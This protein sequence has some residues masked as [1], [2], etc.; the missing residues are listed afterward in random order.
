M[1]PITPIVTHAQIVRTVIEESRV[2]VEYTEGI[3]DEA[4]AYKP[5]RSLTKEITGTDYAALCGR[6]VKIEDAS[7]MQLTTLYEV[8]KIELYSRL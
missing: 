7:S 5:L 6:P 3:T 4:G 8:I 2:L 1:Q